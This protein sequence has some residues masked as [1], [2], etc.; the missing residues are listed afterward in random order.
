MKNVSVPVAIGVSPSGNREILAL[1]EGPKEDAALGTAFLRGLKERGLKSVELFVSG[2]GLVLVKNLADFYP[3]ALWQCCVAYF[4]RNVWTAKPTGKVKEVAATLKAIHAQEDAKAAKIHSSPDSRKLR[5][6]QL[7]M[8]A[9]I[10]EE[11]VRTS[12]KDEFGGRMMRVR[13]DIKATCNLIFGILALAVDQ[14]LRLMT[15][16]DCRTRKPE[17]LPRAHKVSSRR[18]E[19][20]VLAPR[21]CLRSARCGSRSLPTPNR[22]P[23]SWQRWKSCETID[24]SLIL[25]DGTHQCVLNCHPIPWNTLQ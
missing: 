21:P 2:K 24:L 5:L 8:A 13:G 10:V 20:T 11:R 15:Q 1:S 6:M 22:A 7:S 19:I 9:E 4:Y 16:R 23:S 18:E 12:L 25:Q 3:D 14:T 17:K